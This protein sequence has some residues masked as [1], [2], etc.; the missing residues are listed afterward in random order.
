MGRILVSTLET[1][2][3]NATAWY[4][5]KLIF[6]NIPLWMV[7][8]TLEKTYNVQIHLSSSINTKD[9]FTGT[10]T[11]KSLNKDLEILEASCHFH[12]KYGATR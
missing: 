2:S 10:I 1:V 4:C 3:N 11:S 8:S 7:L 9:L 12:T 6:R 5:Q